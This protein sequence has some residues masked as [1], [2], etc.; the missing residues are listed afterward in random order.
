MKIIETFFEIFILHHFSKKLNYVQTL[1]AN[2]M[3]LGPYL[4]LSRH[5]MLFVVSVFHNSDFRKRMS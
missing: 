1:I 5:E 3:Y 2:P 4:N